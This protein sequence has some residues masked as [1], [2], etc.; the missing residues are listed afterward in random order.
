[1]LIVVLS[2]ANFSIISFPR[3]IGSP[4]TSPFC[5]RLILIIISPNRYS[6]QFFLFFHS[7][8]PMILLANK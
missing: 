1:M 8:P 7:L 3:N 2:S 4:K 5:L 6:Y